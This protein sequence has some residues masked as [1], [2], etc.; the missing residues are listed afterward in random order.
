VQQYINLLVYLVVGFAGGFIGLKSRLPAGTMLGAALA[1]IAVK[2]IA[3]TSWD[4][5]KGYGFLCQVLL[6]V[7]IALTYTPGMF[8]TLGQLVVPM[9]LSTL[10]LVISGLVIAFAVNKYWPLDLP[11]A[12]IAT[13][14]GGM[15]ALVPM[16]VDIEGNAAL[17]GSFHFFRI[18]FVVATAPFILRLMIK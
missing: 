5:P 7:L 4:T 8:R 11:T 13:S 17:I 2:I 18:F 3:H 16:A 10:L 1:V 9:F 14:P 6:G 12:Y 15:S